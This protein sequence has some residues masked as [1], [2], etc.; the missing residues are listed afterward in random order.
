MVDKFFFSKASSM[1]DFFVLAYNTCTLY[2][3]ASAC[4]CIQDK[5]YI[6]TDMC[7]SMCVSLVH[8]HGL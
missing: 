6:Y 2:A 8:G 3:Y 5:N 7:G 4:L 1:S